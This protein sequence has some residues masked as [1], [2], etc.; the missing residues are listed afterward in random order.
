MSATLK[1]TVASPAQTF[2]EP[3]VVSEVEHFLGLVSLSPDDT[4]RTM[5]LE[6][7][8]VSAREMAESFQNRDLI[9]KQYD[10]RMSYFPCWHVRLRAPLTSV[11]LVTYKDSDGTT[12]TLAE[13]TDY[14][15]DTERDT[16]VI[17]PPYGNTW[18]SFTPWPS[19]AVLVRFTSGYA[20]D[21]LFWSDAGQRILV[22]MKLLISDWYQERLPLDL[23]KDG[24]PRRIRALLSHGANERPA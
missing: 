2:S 19:S 9:E 21:D 1:L 14:I 6:G 7:L 17:L 11:D 4:E 18:P 20:S 8:I 16:G 10:L 15:V 12:T 22:G 3:L 23:D 24:V 13:N 5:L